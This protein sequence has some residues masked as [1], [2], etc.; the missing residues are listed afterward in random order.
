MIERGRAVDALVTGRFDLVVV[1]GGITGA[2]VV[3]DAASR[4]F[5][6][7]LVERRDFASG[8]S[9]RS[10]KLV[11]GG[12]RYLRGLH[13]RQVREA[14]RERQL[15]VK[16]APRLVRPLPLIVPAFNG[17]RP[18]RLLGTALTAYD[19]L[20][21][22]G[23][24]TP[25]RHRAISGAEVVDLVP[26]LAGRAPTSGFLFHDCQGDDSRLV[27]TVLDAA[28]RLGA[29]CANRLEAVGLIE[30]YGRISGVRVR[31]A[32]THERFTITAD[33]VVNA[34]G[35]WADRIPVEMDGPGA[36]APIIQPSRGTHIILRRQ[37]LL[38]EEA[39]TVVPSG[40]RRHV[41]AVPWLGQVLV[42]AT[43][44]E[45][46]GDLDDVRPLVD[47]VDYLLEAVNAFFGTA[48]GGCEVAGAFA[49]ARPLIARGGGRQSVD[50]SRKAALFESQSGLITI[51]GGKLT[52]WRR[53]AKVTVDRLAARDG[54][55]APCRT[56]EIALAPPFDAGDL[57]PVG[58]VPAGAYAHLAARYGPVAG[59]V[60]AVAAANREWA[61][62]I[63]ASQPDLL[64]EAV[65]AA[66]HEQARTV[67]DVLLRRTRVGLLAAREACD[68][69]GVVARRVANAMAHELRWSKGRADDEASAWAHVAQAEGIV[70]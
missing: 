32:E 12:L 66:R 15:M 28:E 49:G 58:R 69:S 60:L 21:I 44:D 43:D 68:P 56:H 25:E 6:V 37:D 31:D 38:L 10:S 27:L 45:H 22:R 52:T 29:V 59:E 40:R 1:G 7:A 57:P 19:L 39:G 4:G 55:R 41:L 35:V 24:R 64:A 50:R 48:L 53:M 18:D 13:L 70:V 63:V 54:R 3:L 17:A 65:F 46:D 67:A 14:L 2:G 23:W 33:R 30:R 61:Q 5:S 9:S 62:P 36:G 11:H 47:D 20:A 8:T 34:T 51:T 16:L 26:A 42:G